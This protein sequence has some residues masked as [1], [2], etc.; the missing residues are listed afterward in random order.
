MRFEPLPWNR[1]RP[2]AD[3]SSCLAA[4]SL[5]MDARR[6]SPGVRSRHRVRLLALVLAL[7]QGALISGCGN[8]DMPK[9]TVQVPVIS[10]AQLRTLAT[11]RIY[12][13]HQSVGFDIVAG[14]DEVLAELGAHG[15]RVVELH[16]AAGMSAPA[17]THASIGENEKPLSKIA[18]F[19]DVVGNEL[20]GALDIAF[21]KFCYVDIKPQTDVETLFRNYRDA[22]RELQQ[23][24]PDVRLLHLTA[25][26]TV[27]Q[28]GPKAWIKGIIGRPD[29]HALAN[30]QRARY[31]ELVR[32]EY[33]AQEVFDLAAVESTWENGHRRTFVVDGRTY[34]ALVE[35]YTHDGRH[36]N[37]R[38]RRWVAQNLLAFLGNLEADAGQTR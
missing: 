31:N 20:G 26:L 29:L 16:A 34:D 11:Q 9:P 17:F 7:L 1:L 27:I 30:L 36:L 2:R 25:P 10:E 24:Y 18:A 28:S 22:M 8:P 3:D 5:P 15:V 19:G 32:A 21:F 23:R 4:R 37:Q 38:G 14:V 13:G 6:S 35:D 33:A 12:F